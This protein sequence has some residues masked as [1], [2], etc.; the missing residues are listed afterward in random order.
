MFPRLKLVTQYGSQTGTNFYFRRPARITPAAFLNGPL[1]I[2]TFYV[3][4]AQ[5]DRHSYHGDNWIYP[6]EYYYCYARVCFV[7]TFV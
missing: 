3:A 1:Y 4:Y 6:R 7:R 2:I 5:A